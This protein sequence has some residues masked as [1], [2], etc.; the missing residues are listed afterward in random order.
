MGPFGGP[1]GAPS[2]A[3]KM[4]SMVRQLHV[5]KPSRALWGFS[6]GVLCRG[7]RRVL[8]RSLQS[9][10]TGGHC[11]L[12]KGGAQGRGKWEGSM[13]SWTNE[14]P[15]PPHAP[16]F[17]GWAGIPWNTCLGL[18][19]TIADRL[20]LARTS[21]PAFL[22]L[23]LPS[24][25]IPPPVLPGSV[26]SPC[27]FSRSPTSPS[28]FCPSPS[29]SRIVLLPLTVAMLAHAGP[30]VRPRARRNKAPEPLRVEK[31]MYANVSLGPRYSECGGADVR[32]VSTR[33]WQWPRRR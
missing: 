23:S 26:A 33:F 18:C 19:K 31:R 8:Q 20:S 17:R 9:L 24:I 32:C 14:F 25:S 5:S 13:R 12:L 21:L 6:Q 4:T 1:L 29:F 27:P 7:L 16:A 10:C 30:H 2:R 28:Q 11:R 3:L 15:E 22:L